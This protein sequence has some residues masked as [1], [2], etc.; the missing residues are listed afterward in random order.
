MVFAKDQNDAPRQGRRWTPFV[1]LAGGLVISFL[2]ANGKPAPVAG[3]PPE[4]SPLNVTFASL[5]P[6]SRHLSVSTQGTL[7]SRRETRLTAQ[8]S[9][10]VTAV[11]E[12]LARG[13]TVSEGEILLQI[14]RRDYEI[15]V[16]EVDAQL[17]EAEQILAIERGRARQA[18]REWRDLGSAD[19]NDLFLRKPQLASAEAGVAGAQAKLQRAQLNLQRT[20]ITSPYAGIISQVS[21][22]LGQYLPAGGDIGTV[23]DARWLELRLPVSSH[24]LSLLPAVSDGIEATIISSDGQ[25]LFKTTITRL[26]AAADPQS[27]F[28]YLIADLRLSDDSLPLF[29][30]QFVEATLQGK[31]FDSTIAV[32]QN[33][34][35]ARDELWI[36]GSDQSLQKTRARVLQRKGDEFILALDTKAEIVKV[37]TSYIAQPKV[38]MSITGQ[39]G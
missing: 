30:G 34:L 27:R 39:Q 35:R 23:T 38:G 15:A 36:I 11:S 3:P 20:Q 7:E 19:A 22:Q 24:E 14:D 17:A 6:Q 12:A 33:A 37:I 29:A 32:P 18:K 16:K 1:L 28:L 13:Q 21:A 4:A 5:T 9:G 8:V 25:E 31:L 26:Q 10:S 2:I